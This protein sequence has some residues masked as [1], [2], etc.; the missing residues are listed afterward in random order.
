MTT[1]RPARIVAV[2][3]L[4]LDVLDDLEKRPASDLSP[5]ED[6]LMF[7]AMFSRSQL[8]EALT[9]ARAEM[10]AL[11]PAVLAAGWGVVTST[12]QDRAGAQS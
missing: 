6:V 12:P 7:C 1:A 4:L 11:A 5:A 2:V 3:Q 9:L 8:D 10:A